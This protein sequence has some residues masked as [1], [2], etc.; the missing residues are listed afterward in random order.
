MLSNRFFRWAFIA[1][2]IA[3]TL[4]VPKSALAWSDCGPTYVVQWGDT[5]GSVSEKCGIPVDDLYQANPNVGYMLY[6]G[7]TLV[8]PGNYPD[9]GY[10]D[11]CQTSDCYGYQNPRNCD[12]YPG[13]AGCGGFPDVYAR[14][15]N[16]CGRR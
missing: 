14:H 16:R 1:V 2:L 11:G 13:S 3:V 12:G 9:G 6:A 15:N 7:Q 4:A 10:Y 5:L 8:I